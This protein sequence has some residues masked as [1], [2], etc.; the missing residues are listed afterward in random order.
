MELALRGTM[1]V[2]V[3]SS[4]ER[5]GQAA[6][7]RC[8]PAAASPD[9][10]L[11]Q[12]TRLGIRAALVA[13][14]VVLGGACRVHTNISVDVKENGSGTV[15]VEIGLDDDALKKAPNL[16]QT[17]RVQDLTAHG[18]TVTGPVKEDD[19]FTYVTATKPFANPDEVIGIFR[20]ISGDKGPFR[21]FTLSRNR[22]FA[23]TKFH[24]SGT[25][26]FTAGLEA[27]SDSQL[28]QELDGKP[29]G[30]DIK[31][32]EQRIN[33]SLDKVFEFQVRVRMPGGVT[34]NA[35]TQATNG[36]VWQ[37]RLSQGGPVTLEASSTSTRWGTIVGALALAVGV[38]GL[39]VVV[40]LAWLLRRSRRPSLS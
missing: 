25:V 13:A 21:N 31:A 17:L 7:C 10:T 33:E 16:E 40:P 30:E 14:V 23:R 11:Q 34:S 20:E 8:A 39:V 6:A 38:L 19:G 3:S 37:P 18:W 1:R 28:A 12:R 4:T 36:A 27:F 26:D 2:M 24:F 32:I 35:P 29:I 22:T 9:S 15:T 5:C